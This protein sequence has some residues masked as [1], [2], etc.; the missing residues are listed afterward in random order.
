MKDEND[1]PPKFSQSQYTLMMNENNSPNTLLATLIATDEDVGRNGDVRYSLKGEDAATFT[2]DKLSGDLRARYSLNREDKDVY[3]LIAVAEDDGEDVKLSNSAKVTIKIVDENDNK[4][5]LTNIVS[6][7]N[8]P[9]NVKPV[10]PS[11]SL[12]Q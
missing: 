9:D 12:T 6:S 7:L 10:T 1:N 5:V 3:E 2:I 11:T 4:P 8:I